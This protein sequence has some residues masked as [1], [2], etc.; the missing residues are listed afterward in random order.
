MKNPKYKLW[1]AVARG[2]GSMLISAAAIASAYRASKNKPR[3]RW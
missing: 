2:L 3:S 1:M